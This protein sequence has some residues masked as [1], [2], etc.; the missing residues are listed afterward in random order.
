MSQ[1]NQTRT[2]NPEATVVFIRAETI[3][4][5]DDEL[6]L[7]LMMNFIHHL[8]VTEPAPSVI[9]AMNA[10]VKLVIE[11]SD[12]L[13]DLR[14]LERKGARILACGTCL[15]FFGV[16]EKQKVGVVSNM[17]EITKTLLEAKK[18]ITV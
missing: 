5:G 15:N 3:G 2:G 4:R 13:E 10:G 18:V 17:V 14:E 8:S 11:G 16:K 6:G 1:E 9:I 12:V 7:N